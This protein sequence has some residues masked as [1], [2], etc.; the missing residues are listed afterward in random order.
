MF[1]GAL[2]TRRYTEQE[3]IALARK[4][5]GERYLYVGC[6][7]AGMAAKVTIRCL[8]HGSFMQ[9]ALDHV[10]GSGCPHC[11]AKARQRGILQSRA[12]SRIST[13]E[14]IAR[15]EDKHGQ[16]Y[17]YAQ[18]KGT[19]TKKP[20]TIVCRQHGLFQQLPSNHLR[21]S[22]CP[23]CGILR[24]GEKRKLD[25][26]EFE[27]RVR[28]AHGD[29]YGLSLAV[30]VTQ[31]DN[32]MVECTEHGQFLILPL[33][34]W[35]GGGCPKCA[36][37]QNGLNHRITQD[38]YLC[39]VDHIHGTTYDHSLIQFEHMRDKI[40]VV[41]R[42]H[43]QFWP[44]AANYLAGR[45]CPD[46]GSS[47]AAGKRTPKLVLKIDEVLAR[48][49]EIHGDQYDYTK[50]VYGHSNCYVEIVCRQHGSFLQ[51]PSSHWMGKG[52]PECGRVTRAANQVL[53]TEEVIARFR[54]LHGDRYDYTDTEYGR[55]RQHVMIR[56]RR[57]GS[58]RQTPQAHLEGKGCPRCSQS[59]GETRAA[60]WLLERGIEFTVEF[61]VAI[62]GST[63]CRFD[64]FLP[65][66]CAF[67]EI[68]GPHHYAPVQYAGMSLEKA[69][70]VFQQT[71]R[72]DALKGNWATENGVL[73]YRIRWDENIEERLGQLLRVQPTNS[74]SGTS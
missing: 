4:E 25:Q 27:K 30:Y 53:T 48:F 51:A 38:D 28:A 67:L 58:F 55:F 19:G 26:Q 14:L 46:C 21:G 23:K 9:K 41:C 36:R 65:D 12:K 63:R 32:V 10:K 64:F 62:E 39:R 15:F 37:R 7:Y 5:H 42:D 47:R 59:S 31:Y 68:D 16:T 52:C 50:V 44:T 20:V 29:R 22:G 54:Q 74:L 18:V 35:Q 33:N 71:Q 40:V 72:R 24:A 8:E 69:Q 43:G 11:G 6:G 49:R 3:W 70:H 34:L 73:V 13:Q 57:H 45:G 17:D 66:Q 2:V 56:C 61:P 60:A 1:L